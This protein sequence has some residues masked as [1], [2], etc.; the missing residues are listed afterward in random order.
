[1][2]IEIEPHSDT[3][4]PDDVRRRLLL[5]GLAGEAAFAMSNTVQAQE[6]ATSAKPIKQGGEAN[7]PEMLQ[8]SRG[9]PGIGRAIAV[10]M[11]A[12]GAD[13]ASIDICGFVNMR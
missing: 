7:S 13:I 12:N 6:K 9:R 1:M 5:G 3:Q 4:R 10:E 11:A 8:S 2:T